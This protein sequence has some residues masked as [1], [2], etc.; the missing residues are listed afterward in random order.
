MVVCDGFSVVFDGSLSLV[1]RW[2]GNKGFSIA[3]PTI[4][5]DGFKVVFGQA[6]F[7]PIFFSMVADHWSNDEMVM[8]HRCGLLSS[9]V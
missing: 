2:N 6:T 4:G 9:L 1:K 3:L 8:I 7:A 5:I